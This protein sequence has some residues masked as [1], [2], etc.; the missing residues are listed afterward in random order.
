MIYYGKDK[1]TDILGE[2]ITVGDCIVMAKGGILEIG[3]IINASDTT[4]HLETIDGHKVY[5]HLCSLYSHR[6]FKI[7]IAEFNRIEG[8][9]KA[10]LQKDGKSWANRWSVGVT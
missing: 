4:I 5:P 1:I 3:R 10:K 2:P 9:V 7:P 8:S 6:I